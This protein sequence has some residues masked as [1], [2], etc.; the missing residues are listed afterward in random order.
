MLATQL[1]QAQF[2]LLGGRCRCIVLGAQLRLEVRD[3]L[4]MLR[5]QIAQLLLMLRLGRCQ[6]LGV[7]GRLL[8]QL[9]LCLLGCPGRRLLLG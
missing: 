6:L 4:G 2:R 9:L 1:C 3:L 5:L 8:R 7:H